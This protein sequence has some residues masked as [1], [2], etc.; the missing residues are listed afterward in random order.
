MKPLYQLVTQHR[1]L[2][3]LDA[4]EVDEQTLAD[5]LEALEGEIEIKARSCAA[6]IQNLDAFAEM[7]KDASKKLAERAARIE[8]KSDWL[9]SYLLHQMRGA[10]LTKI[11][12][13]EFTVSIRK[14]PAAVLIAEH[15]SIPAEYMVQP[16]PPPPRPD[17][18]KLKEALEHGAVIDGV[19]LEQTERLDIR[20]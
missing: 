14:N 6:H 8:R 17:K 19:A 18:K 2:E 3:V 16:E 10:G 5:T 15:A 13:P 7:V 9:R 12:A 1:A 20:N 11:K 4:E